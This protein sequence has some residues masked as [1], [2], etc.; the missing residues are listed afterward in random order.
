MFRR[1]YLHKTPLDCDMARAMKTCVLIA[2]KNCE[3]EMKD[4]FYNDY[5]A[6]LKLNSEGTKQPANI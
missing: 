2:A 6:K 1:F 5:F 3:I 4:Q